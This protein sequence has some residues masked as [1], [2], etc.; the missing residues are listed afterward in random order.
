MEAIGGSWGGENR[1][2]MLYGAI[3]AIVLPIAVEWA[4]RLRTFVGILSMA[5]NHDMR[6]T[7]S[8]S[9]PTFEHSGLQE[10]FFFFPAV[11]FVP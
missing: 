4:T 5:V 3:A 7:M 9:T 10:R 1:N 6:K 2:S 11:V 8:R